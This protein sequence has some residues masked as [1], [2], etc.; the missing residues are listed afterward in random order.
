MVG[1][2]H[3][4]GHS[5]QIGSNVCLRRT[6]QVYRRLLRWVTLKQRLGRFGFEN[7]R[8]VTGFA[9]E[10]LRQM[11]AF[12]HNAKDL[13]G[14]FALRLYLLHAKHLPPIGMGS[15]AFRGQ[16]RF[17]S[18]DG[19]ENLPR[20]FRR[21][22]RRLPVRL[23]SVSLGWGQ[24]D[25]LRL[26]CSRKRR[27]GWHFSHGRNLRLAARKRGEFVRDER[28]GTLLDHQATAASGQ[29]AVGLGRSINLLAGIKILHRNWSADWRIAVGIVH[30]R[31]DL[32]RSG[33]AACGAGAFFHLGLGAGQSPGQNHAN[34]RTQSGHHQRQHDPRGYAKRR[35][36]SG[37]DQIDPGAQHHVLDQRGTY[38]QTAKPEQR[39]KP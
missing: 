18:G 2:R 39:A 22:L 13:T 27:A 11:I 34:D 12:C 26:D 6:V 25:G 23:G 33:I 31:P 10:F 3:R 16:C 28:I 4:S 14:L 17:C 36:S 29:P 30:A 37:N 1:R 15:C 8:L 19:P 9:H 21:L 38:G 35:C 32:R 24:L 7:G 20:R 5:L